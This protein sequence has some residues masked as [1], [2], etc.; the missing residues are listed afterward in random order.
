MRTLAI[1]LTVLLCLSPSSAGEAPDPAMNAISYFTDARAERMQPAIDLLIEKGDAA[2]IA[3]ARPNA[4]EA[5]SEGPERMAYDG[6]SY[7]I[8]VARRYAATDAGSVSRWMTLDE[9]MRSGWRGHVAAVVRRAGMTPLDAARVLAERAEAELA[10]QECFAAALGDEKAQE[11]AVAS[12]ARRGNAIVPHA[13][14]VLAISPWIASAGWPGGST[15]MHQRLA[16]RILTALNARVAIPYLLL[17]VDAPSAMLQFDALRALTLL[18]GDDSWATKDIS[19]GAELAGH[20]AV[21]WK[22]HGKDHATGARWCALTA[23]AVATEF[24]VS[25]ELTRKS[26]ANPADESPEPVAHLLGCLEWMTG[27]TAAGFREDD[28]DSAF[29]RGHYVADAIRHF[30]GLD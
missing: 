22:L 4:R 11:L 5:S 17:H 25:L 8:D 26:A 2:R 28:D 27:Y 9:L 12:A 1:A 30:Q 18:T 24:L 21:W 10:V 23:L 29:G 6:V 14:A 19:K 20:R 3:V 16:V 7:C 15:V 13:L